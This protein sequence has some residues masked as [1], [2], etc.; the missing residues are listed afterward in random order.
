M[1]GRG[2]LAA[3]DGNV[4]VRVGPERLLI[5]PSGARKGFL[6]PED[7]VLCDRHGHVE[8]GQKARPSSEMGMHLAVYAAR[9]ELRAVVH[10][11]PPAAVAHTVAGVPIEPLMPEVFCE[12]GDVRTLDYS[13]P[14]TPSVGA[15]VS[16]AIVG[17][18]ALLMARHG[19]ITVG[20]T[21]AEAYDRLEILEHAARIS[22]MARALAPGAVRPLSAEALAALS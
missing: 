18:V 17:R 16:E 7:C 13:T 8:K 4:S 12:L 9:P 22:L 10:A 1:H 3:R 5:T 19:S 21:L 11:H 20:R 2:L 15:A 6:G 14:G